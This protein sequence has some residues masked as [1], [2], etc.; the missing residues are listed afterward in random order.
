[1]PKIKVLSGDDAIKILAFFGFSVVSQK[2]SHIKLR[3]VINRVNQNLTIPNHKELD[4]GTLKAIFNQASR[5]VSES[6]LMP[7]FY[8]E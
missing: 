1:M 6:E 5:Y 3:R 8:S 2:G 7:Y 4:K